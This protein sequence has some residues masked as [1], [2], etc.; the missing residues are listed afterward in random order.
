MP[1]PFEGGCRC[2][3]VRYRCTAQPAFVVHC[4]CRDCQYASGGASST[5]AIVMA[6]SLTID[7]RPASFSSQADSGTT[8]TRQFCAKC[9][10]PVFASNAAAPTV[11]AIKAATLDDPSWLEPSA[12]I[13]VGS[14][15]R[16]AHI[17][18]DLPRFAKNVG[19][20]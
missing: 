7:G 6:D 1:V 8:V 18:D 13:W 11:V 10:S 2:G 12:N 9:G 4:Y 5:G 17:G 15:P 19:A 20:S 16:W 3:A 14:A